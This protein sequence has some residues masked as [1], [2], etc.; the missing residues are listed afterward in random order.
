MFKN[1]CYR[2]CIILEVFWHYKIDIKMPS[3]CK[4]FALCS[5]KD[6]LNIET[7]KEIFRKETFLKDGR[8]DV[9]L[10]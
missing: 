4:I 1:V 6:K 5:Q 8:P 9:C 3:K 10:R 7:Q 2:F